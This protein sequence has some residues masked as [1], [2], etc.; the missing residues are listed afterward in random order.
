MSRT[1]T[2]RGFT[3]IEMIVV[4]AIAAILAAYAIPRYS[5]FANATFDGW[6]DE[7]VS[8]LQYARSSAVSHRRLVCITV[9]SQSVSLR[10]ASANPATS[11]NLDLSGPSGGPA[12]TSTAKSVATSVSPSGVL[13]VQSD[14][15]VTTDGAGTT[16]ATFT[17]SMNGA[18]SITIHGETG[19]VE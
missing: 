18:A 6:H 9:A 13:Y 15:R 4:M 11:C 8:T 7:V 19:H 2:E 16:T 14:G 1:D 17:V 5:S 12:V 3:M 10:I